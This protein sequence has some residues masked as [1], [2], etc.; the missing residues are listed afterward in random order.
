MVRGYDTIESKQL[1]DFHDQ[2]NATET[3]SSHYRAPTGTCTTIW[4]VTDLHCL[5]AWQML[6]QTNTC[7]RM[8]AQCTVHVFGNVV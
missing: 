7:S 1:D 4:N 8:L 3:V 6:L 5:L 2:V